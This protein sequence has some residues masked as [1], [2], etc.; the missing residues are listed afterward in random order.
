[1][2]GGA[3]VAL[4]GLRARSEHLDRLAADI[5]NASTSGYKAERGT[6]E[7]AERLTF[8][9]ALESAIDVANGPTALDLRAGAIA[10]TGRDLDVAI[11]GSGFFVVETPAGPRYTRNGHFERRAD[12]TLTTTEGDVVQGE[13]GPI[14]LGP[15]ALS[16]A[17]DGTI[18]SGNAVAGRLRIVDFPDASVLAREGAARFNAGAVTPVPVTAPQLEPGALEKSNVSVV[19]RIAELTEASRTFEALQRG[20][21]L[22]LNDIDGRAIS[23]LGRR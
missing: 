21:G 19:D 14:Q 2:A 15:G 9:R 7:A 22:I 11:R 6:T 8:D 17:Q 23:E 5:A 13:G 12:G 4:S 10:T 16:I 18:S 20:V 3:Y 1:M